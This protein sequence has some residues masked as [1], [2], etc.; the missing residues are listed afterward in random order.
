MPLGERLGVRLVGRR[1]GNDLGV[2]NR[3]QRLA[4]DSG[5][6]LRA[7]QAHSYGFHCWVN[8]MLDTADAEK[9]TDKIPVTQ[10]SMAALLCAIFTWHAAVLRGNLN[11]SRRTNLAREGAKL[12][13]SLAG[14]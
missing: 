13:P 9:C 5:N 10:G 1:D 7:H 11:L 3:P 4:M 14:A 6:K 12:S 8:L 2:R